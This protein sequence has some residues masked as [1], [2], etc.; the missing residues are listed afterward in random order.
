[1]RITSWNFLH[2]QTI[3]QG[4]APGEALTSGQVAASLASDLLALQEI[5]MNLERS[6]S[7]N[8]IADIAQSMGAVA[9]GFAPA[10]KGTPGFSW[11][12]LTSAETRVITYIEE[13]SD[14][15][16]GIGIASKIPVKMLLPMI[17]CIFPALLLVVIGPAMIQIKT[18][19]N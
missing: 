19:F 17:F 7:V 16:Y 13:S 11:R 3:Q 6:G 15:L 8:Q 1:M 4:Q 10:L 9:W 5:D 12:K 14:Q 18:L 2:G